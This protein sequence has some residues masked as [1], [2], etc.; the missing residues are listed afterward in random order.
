[1][2]EVESL[3]KR[4]ILLRKVSVFKTK[5]CIYAFKIIWSKICRIIIN[6]AIQQKP[7]H[8]FCEF[9]NVFMEHQCQNRAWGY[10]A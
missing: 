4:H 5:L 6:K 9:S 7:S 2:Q 1:M 8:I 10:Q 3:E